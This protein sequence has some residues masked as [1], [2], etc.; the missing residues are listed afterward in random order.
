[1]QSFE[2]SIHNNHV[3]VSSSSSLLLEPIQ[4]FLR[5]FSQKEVDGIRVMD[6]KFYEVSRRDEIPKVLSTQAKEVIS[7]SGTTRGDAKRSTWNYTLYLEPQKTIADY[8]EQGLIVIDFAS[9][10]AQ[11]YVV[12]PEAMHEDVRVSYF[13]YALIELLK[14]RGF[15]TLHATALEKNG[16][17]ILIPGCSGRGKTTAFVS[18]LRSGYR[19]LSDDHPLLHEPHG[20]LELLAFEEKVDITE[21][22]LK[23]FPEFQNAGKDILPDGL[24]KRYFFIEDFYKDGFAMS[25][26]P[27][28]LLFPQVVD[29]P[30]SR[31]EPLPKARA[32][33]ELLP[34]TMD[35]F[36]K[37][38]AKQE[39]SFLSRLVNQLD[40]YQLYFG[41]DVL[42]LPNL[43]TPLLEKTA[44]NCEPQVL[45]MSGCL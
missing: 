40:C 9:E 26:Q 18:L 28:M 2:V 23:F 20:E 24:W 10:S 38:I 45:S 31:V 15:Y 35:V 5:Y 19:C 11:I 39:F 44:G 43:I 42:E 29:S 13:H 21:N 4:K 8:H 12:E 36:D 14:R 1:M 7:R 41:H 34:E 33:E 32:L 27:R 17:G 30:I 6:F 25:C 3:K 22:S 16:L 37:T